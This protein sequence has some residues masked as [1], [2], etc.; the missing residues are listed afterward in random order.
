MRCSTLPRGSSAR[1][2]TANCG[3]LPSR[4]STSETTS[5]CSRSACRGH[6]QPETAEPLDVVALHLVFGLVGVEVQRMAAIRHLGRTVDPLD[7]AEEILFRPTSCGCR[8]F[9]DCRWP[10]LGAGVVALGLAGLLLV[11]EVD[12]LAGAV[13][14]HHP[15]LAFRRLDDSSGPLLR[16]C[17]RRGR[18]RRWWEGFRLRRHCAGGLC[19]FRNARCGS[20]ASGG[21]P[22]ASQHDSEYSKRGEAHP[23]QLPSELDRTAGRPGEVVTSSV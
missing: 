13:E 5:G 11:E 22:A 17:R 2:A 20:V 6:D 10:C 16:G 15:E 18:I 12:R 8:A 14:K 9:G 19:L 21:I 1:S 7:G 3:L 4:R 23:K